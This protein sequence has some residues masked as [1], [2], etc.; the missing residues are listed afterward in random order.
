MDIGVAQLKA[1]CAAFAFAFFNSCDVLFYAWH[2]E[3]VHAQDTEPFV[4]CL[5]ETNGYEDGCIRDQLREAMEAVRGL[6]L[7]YFKDPSPYLIAD[8]LSIIFGSGYQSVRAKIIQ[9]SRRNFHF[10]GIKF[11]YWNINFD[12]QSDRVWWHLSERLWDWV[13][14]K[15]YVKPDSGRRWAAIEDYL[16]EGAGSWIWLDRAPEFGFIE[17]YLNLNVQEISL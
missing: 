17:H 7:E 13:P 9:C 11:V 4:Y 16:N 12:R 14:A 15:V 10:C 2:C 3:P 8:G 1:G 5:H 6:T